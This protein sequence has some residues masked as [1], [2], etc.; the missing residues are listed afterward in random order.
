MRLIV[1][2]LVFSYPNFT[3]KVKDLNFEG[4]KI[5]SIV[6]PNGAGKST[7][8]RCLGVIN[9]VEKGSIFINGKDISEIKENQ[10]ARIIGY[11]PQEQ[12]SIFNFSILDFVLMGRTPYINILS[13]P[14]KKDIE[15]AEDALKFVGIKDYERRGI[16]E[17]S[18]GERRLVLI[19]RTIAQEPEVFLMDEPTSFLD[20]K[21]EIE[22][23]ELVK[24]LS[25]KMRKTVVLT[26]H[27]LDMA[28]KYSHNLVFMKNGE[29]VESGKTSEILSEEI[30]ERVYDIKMKIVDLNGR[31][32]IIR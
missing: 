14:S 19:A 22:I 23:M 2:D 24:N 21:H 15:L 6:G 17:I 10:R 26:L 4:S 1:K 31:K 30:L 7:L 18:S 28:I 27:N 8:L 16:L 32:I 3:L 20:P 9:R 11:I 29:I 12:I 25:E 5:T 13:K